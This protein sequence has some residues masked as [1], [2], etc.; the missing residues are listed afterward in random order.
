MATALPCTQ[1]ALQ[2]HHHLNPT[3]PEHCGSEL[4]L[5]PESRTSLL[6]SYATPGKLLKLSMFHFSS[7]IRQDDHLS[8]PKTIDD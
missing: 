7:S 5:C 8:V 1:A 2:H 4:G 3:G 6:S